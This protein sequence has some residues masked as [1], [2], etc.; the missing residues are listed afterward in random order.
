MGPTGTFKENPDT[1]SV[2]SWTFPE[3]KIHFPIYETLSPDSS[4][5]PYDVM[6]HIQD[7]EQPSVSPLRLSQTTL[8]L[9]NFKCVTLRVR[10]QVDMI[11][12]PLRSITISGTWMPIMTPTSSTK[13]VIGVNHN[14]NVFHFLCDTIFYLP[15]IWSAV[16]PYLAQSRY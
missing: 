12:T 14:V 5:A 4:G 16:S 10:E 9:P 8:A 1:I 11:E 3:P 7:S 6:D 15:E 13:I 2:N